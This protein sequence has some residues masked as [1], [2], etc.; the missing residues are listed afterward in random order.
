[1]IRNLLFH[2][3]PKK[4]SIWPWHVEQLLKYRDVWNGRKIITIALDD[5]TEDLKAVDSAL[6][7]LGAEIIIGKNDPALGET[8]FFIERL[9][10]LES[11]N[12]DEATFYAHSK[13]V[14]RRKGLLAAS[15][16]WTQAMYT[17][18][19]ESIPSVEAALARHGMVGCFRHQ[20]K[21]GG[22]L[23]CYAGTFFWIRHK[24]LFSRNWKRIRRNSIYGVEGYPGIHFKWGELG[25]FTPDN[26]SPQWLY[27]GGV[28]EEL[29]V[30]WKKYWSLQ[31]SESTL[32]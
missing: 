10:L 6:A 29:I 12:P 7:P 8:K 5:Q 21:H 18:N 14:T 9:G 20:I 3:Y 4:G 17:L 28:T 30:E 16:I 13:G 31:E 1:M 15:K 27:G 32:P 19:L 25:A 11:T 2:M 22:S 23:R 26:L 24:A